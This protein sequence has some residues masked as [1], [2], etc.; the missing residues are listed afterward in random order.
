METPTKNGFYWAKFKDQSEAS[1]VCVANI[2]SHWPIV[3]LPG[4]DYLFD[5][6]EWLSDKL[7]PP[8]IPPSQPEP[9]AKQVAGD[10]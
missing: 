2:D 6:F 9:T 5:D 7:E 8:T 3:Y 4:D 10:D 1:I